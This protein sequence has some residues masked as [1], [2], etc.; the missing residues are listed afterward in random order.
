MHA[1]ARWKAGLQN[2]ISVFHSIPN[3]Q[4]SCQILR[5]AW[6]KSPYR[7]RSGT[8]PPLLL[9]LFQPE[10][11]RYSPN[12]FPTVIRV[13]QPP[14]LRAIGGQFPDSRRSGRN[15]ATSAVR[16]FPIEFD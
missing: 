2:K 11:S 15:A 16:V 7:E 4:L 1:G 14:R 8:C 9:P 5:A 12:D 6:Y 13:T 10:R 3:K